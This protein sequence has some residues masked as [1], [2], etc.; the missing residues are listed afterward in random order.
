M[1]FLKSSYVLYK[2][3]TSHYAQI[4]LTISKNIRMFTIYQ[5]K[6]FFVHPQRTFL[7]M[8]PQKF[9][10]YIVSVYTRSISYV[11]VISTNV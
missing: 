6:V 8:F 3:I 7:R 5:Q 10:K 2:Y 11:T 1:V 4:L 9:T